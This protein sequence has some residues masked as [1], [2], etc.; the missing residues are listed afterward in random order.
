[1]VPQN[2][3][4]LGKVRGE[5]LC[6]VWPTRGNPPHGKADFYPLLAEVYKEV[7]EGEVQGSPFATSSWT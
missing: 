2:I 6:K 4:D 3:D 1:M 5:T 7:I